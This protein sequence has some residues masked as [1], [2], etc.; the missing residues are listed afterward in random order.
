MDRKE[1][2]ELFNRLHETLEHVPYAICGLGALID[3]GF[4]R[5]RA[6]KISIICPQECK[7]NIKAWAAARGYETFVDSIGIPTHHHQQQ[8]ALSRD[9]GKG[10]SLA[11]GAE[12]LRKVR[13]KF[14]DSGFERLEIKRSSISNA[15]VLSMTS[16]LDNV[17]A[18]Y[19][20]H[21]RR[22]DERACKIIVSDVFWCLERVA[23]SPRERLDPD[24]LPTFLGE[25]FFADFTAMNPTARVE[26]ER[27]GI[28][29]DAV[30]AKHHDAAALR[31]H[32]EMLKQY[33]LEG[34]VVAP[35]PGAF[36]GVRDLTNSK[37]VYTLKDRNSHV[38]SNA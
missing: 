27:A 31:E 8:Q 26:M 15:V 16:Q 29:V 11:E 5:R 13:I 9:G 6:N 32:N 17:A 10:R 3:H 18:G 34:D 7:N 22:G 35:N 38:S 21:R 33:G 1:L 36:E 4:T 37:S 25:E 14:I 19:L 20:Y 24:F 23:S 28:D 30:L 2:S 12:R